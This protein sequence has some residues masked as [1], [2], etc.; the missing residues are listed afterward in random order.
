[1]SFLFSTK[2]YRNRKLTGTLQVYGRNLCDDTTHV[3]R[4]FYTAKLYMQHLY[5]V[6]FSILLLFSIIIINIFYAKIKGYS[7]TIESGLILSTSFM[8]SGN[9]GA[10]I[11]LFAYGEAGVAYSARF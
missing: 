10:P 1:M 8:N 9:Y 5:M 11:I 6:F 7:Q 3:F 4:T 2:N